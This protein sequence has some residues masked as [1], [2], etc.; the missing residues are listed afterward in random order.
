MV[1]AANGPPHDAVVLPLVGDLR[2]PLA[3]AKPD[4]F[5]P[6]DLV[7]V[8][9]LRLDLQDA[10]HELRKLFELR[11]GPVR[12]LERDGDVGPALDRQAPR[13]VAAA[14][15]AEQLRGR[16][17]GKSP[18]RAPLLLCALPAPAAERF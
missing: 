17:A 16:L 6:V 7:L 11:P 1:G 3:S 2:V 9:V 4:L 13:L 10:G 15:A 8:V 18:A 12:L 5:A 14:A